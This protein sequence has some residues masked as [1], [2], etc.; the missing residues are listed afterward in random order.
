MT[1]NWRINVGH[2][3]SR[4][5]GFYSEA[6]KRLSLYWW[7]RVNIK[8]YY[9]KQRVKYLIKRETKWINWL[10]QYELSQ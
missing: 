9:L 8:I 1:G 5:N 6:G 10:T 3:Y 4:G 2:D 7:L